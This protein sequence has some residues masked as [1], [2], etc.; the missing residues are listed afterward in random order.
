MSY[1]Y[2]ER[3]LL[4]EPPYHY[5]FTPFEGEALLVGYVQSRRAAIDGWDA[6]LPPPTQAA[7]D[8]PEPG[9]GPIETET[10]LRQ[11]TDYALGRGDCAAPAFCHWAGVFVRKFETFKRL[12]R[13]YTAGLTALDRTPVDG[14]A[15][16]HLGFIAAQVADAEDLRLLNALLKVNDHVLSAPVRED[17]RGLVHHA[18]QR[19][20]S[21]VAGLA[22]RL[23]VALPEMRPC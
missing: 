8:F 21:L 4:A 6:A 23:G 2:T 14:A 11:L 22:G 20:L 13:S 18:V 9:A 19:E 7:G 1:R 5:M 15:Y 17:L 12:R 16:A 10:L 3:D